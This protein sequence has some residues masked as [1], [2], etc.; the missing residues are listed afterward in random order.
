MK[1]L[2]KISYDFSEPGPQGIRFL[3]GLKRAFKRRI[4]VGLNWDLKSNLLNLI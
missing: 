1:V 4:D 2:K 3:W